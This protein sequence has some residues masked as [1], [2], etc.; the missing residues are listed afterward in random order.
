MNQFH[1]A[2]TSGVKRDLAFN[3]R[4]T[5]AVDNEKASFLVF[6][7]KQL[8]LFQKIIILEHIFSERSVSTFFLNL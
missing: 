4:P 3:A 8:N 1:F 6:G 2:A 7:T 5:P